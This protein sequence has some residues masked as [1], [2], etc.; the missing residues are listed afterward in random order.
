VREGTA[1]E[2]R[3]QVNAIEYRAIE[4]GIVGG[5]ATTW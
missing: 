4:V 2:R 5:G 1:R 3:G